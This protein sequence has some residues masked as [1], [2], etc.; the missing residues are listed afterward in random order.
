MFLQARRTSSLIVPFFLMGCEATVDSG[1]DTDSGTVDGL[2]TADRPE[3]QD[4][5]SIDLALDLEALRGVATLV[6]V[7]FREKVRLKV[8][9]LDVLSIKVEGEE[10]VARY[11][12]GWVN[13]PVTGTFEA[14]SVE[15]TYTFL[16][17]TAATFDG[18]MP[19]LGVTFV[20]PESCSNL[21]PCDPSTVDGVTFTMNVSGV[22]DGLTAVYPT[23]THNDGPTYIPAVAVGD[24]TR[25]DLGQNTAG[26]SLSAW[27]LPG[28]RGLQDAEAGT[29]NLVASFD[30]F[31]QNYGPYHFGPEAGTVEVN[32]GPDS[33]GGMEHHPFFHV[34]KFDFNDEEAQVHEAAHGWFGDGVRI[35]CW[36]DFVL[37]EGTTTYITARALEQVG[38]PS[39]WDYYVDDFLV[40]ICEGGSGDPTLVNT[41]V[42]PDTCGEIAFEESDLW[43]ITPYMK[44]AC[45][46]EEVADLVGADLL[47]EVIAEFYTTHVGNAAHMQDMIDLIRA[48]TDAANHAALDS[49][50]DD[51]LLSLECP[52]DYA[53]RCK[54]RED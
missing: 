50:V 34:G 19:A 42:L 29:A 14:V 53:Q 52:D 18:W 38:G 3:A 49:A 5:Q 13:I 51:W 45:F 9:G 22:A 25:L 31:E 15:I 40:G 37:S 20:W 35:A 2:D 48:R 39:V 21:F 24:Y 4:I 44:G 46:Y 10:K 23:S 16:E 54:T 6:V 17:R 11:K 28:E 1:A 27:Y 41:I 47:D 36:E 8:R 12:E 30:Y 26:S 43:S 32:W 7:P 33:W